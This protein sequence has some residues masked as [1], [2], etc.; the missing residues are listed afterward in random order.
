MLYCELAVVL[1]SF[2]QIYQVLKPSAAKL[3]Y[4]ICTNENET[5]ANSQYG[6]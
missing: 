6:I 4:N 5:T 1:F 2:I 3:I